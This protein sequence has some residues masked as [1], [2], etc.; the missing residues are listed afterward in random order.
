MYSSIPDRSPIIFLKTS[1]K[2][3]LYRTWDNCGDLGE[4]GKWDSKCEYRT[5][6]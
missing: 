3:M 6:D 2:E 4:T 5:R 1:R